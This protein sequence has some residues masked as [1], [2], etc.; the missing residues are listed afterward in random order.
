VDNAIRH[1][2][3]LDVRGTFVKCAQPAQ[4]KLDLW[5][6]ASEVIAV[7]KPVTE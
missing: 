7:T 5:I 3:V 4:L 1:C 2:D 6:N